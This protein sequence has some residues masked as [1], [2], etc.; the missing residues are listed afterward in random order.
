MRYKNPE[1]KRFLGTKL[2]KIL[3][4][5]AISSVVLSAPAQAGSLSDPIVTPDVIIADANSSAGGAT[6]IVVVTGI[7]LLAVSMN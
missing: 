1:F 4:A 3:A 6:L 2:T 5:I 7:V